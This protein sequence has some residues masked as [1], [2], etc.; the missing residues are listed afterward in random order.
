MN[1]ERLK[2][3]IK[4]PAPDKEACIVAFRTTKLVPTVLL[5][6]SLGY[7]LITA[8]PRSFMGLVGLTAASEIAAS[9][10]RKWLI[11]YATGRNFI[12]ENS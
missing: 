3:F 1:I 8:E 10:L 6:G 7:F 12:Q 9:F 5:G 11:R 2:N 4:D